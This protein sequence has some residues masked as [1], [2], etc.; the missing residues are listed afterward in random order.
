MLEAGGMRLVEI[1][2]LNQNEI[3]VSEDILPGKVKG[4]L[5]I[6]KWKKEVEFKRIDSEDIHIPKDFCPFELPLE[7]PYKWTVTGDTLKLGPVIAFVVQKKKDGFDWN[8]K[9]RK[10]MRHYQ[11]VNGLVF[12]CTHSRIDLVKE[13]MRGY[14]YNPVKREIDPK[15]RTFPFPDAI[16]QRYPSSK[17][18][19]FKTLQKKV[20]YKLF[21]GPNLNK[22]EQYSILKRNKKLLSHFPT[23]K[24]FKSLK[25]IDNMFEQFP[26]VY[27]KP[28]NSREGRGIITLSKVGN[29]YML[30]S[31]NEK[32]ELN[33]TEL[34]RHL[35][36]LR[37]K[38]KYILQQAA[39][40]IENKNIVL[41][42]IMQKND[43]NEWVYSGG[44]ARIGREGG[45]VTNR[46]YT[47]EFLT[48]DECFMKY[49]HLNE[50][51]AKRFI[52]SIISIC[53]EVCEGYEQAGVSFGDI[54][55]DLIVGKDLKVWV[56]EVNNRSHNHRSPLL[57]L[58]DRHMYRRVTSN[59]L[60][61][62]KYLSGF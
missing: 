29:H 1:Q 13:Q 50:E 36:N 43:R 49:Y 57:T 10:Y 25:S 48:L 24:R 62:A 45:I 27:I 2:G 40:M 52:N 44:Y 7:I 54:A 6:G 59:P 32:R 38:R 37:E 8:K 46:I 39:P 15:E 18:S 35:R 60:L 20:N 47:K 51:E 56:I 41:R 12:V 30:T 53:T 16:F 11:K 42:S 55:F 61:Y 26:T 28:I 4:F 17:R 23:T 34:N 14:Y 9:Y 22:Y 58:R 3:G 33:R 31:E 19:Y 5:E 21:N